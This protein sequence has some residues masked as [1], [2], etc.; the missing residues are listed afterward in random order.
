L[1]SRVAGLG[2]TCSRNPE[3]KEKEQKKRS[4]K[5][6]KEEAQAEKEHDEQE[7]RER[8]RCSKAIAEEEKLLRE[9]MKVFRRT[10]ESFYSPEEYL[11]ERSEPLNLVY[12]DR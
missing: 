2:I 7:A 11:Q 10:G 6:R 4:E 9:R 1:A 3:S 12:I 5:R 8:E